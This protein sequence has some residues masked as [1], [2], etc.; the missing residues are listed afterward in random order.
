MKENFISGDLYAPIRLE[1]FLPSGWSGYVIYFV[2]V[3]PLYNLFLIA[4]SVG[5]H[6]TADYV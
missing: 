3:R 5:C 6:L 2:S 4:V 1:F